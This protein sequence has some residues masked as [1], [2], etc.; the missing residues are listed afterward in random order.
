MS[1]S[2]N[3]SAF[4]VLFVTELGFVIFHGKTAL[5]LKLTPTMWGGYFHAPYPALGIA[6]LLY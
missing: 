4:N 1:H 5:N 3:A 2:Q 6:P